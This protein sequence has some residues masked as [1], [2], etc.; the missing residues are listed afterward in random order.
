[1]NET[2]PTWFGVITAPGRHLV[3]TIALALLIVAATSLS[4]MFPAAGSW[5]FVGTAFVAIAWY[6]YMMKRY[7][8][9]RRP[10]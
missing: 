9:A 2:P 3:L 7:R 5:L 6:S 1:M 4:I 8:A 10:E